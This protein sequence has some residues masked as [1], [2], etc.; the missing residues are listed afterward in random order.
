SFTQDYL[1]QFASD[2]HF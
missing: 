2:T 1:A